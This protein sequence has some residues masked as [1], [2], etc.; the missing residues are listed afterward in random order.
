MSQARASTSRTL[1]AHG[2]L[3]IGIM[4]ALPALAL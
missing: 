3:A 1:A 2:V 4:G